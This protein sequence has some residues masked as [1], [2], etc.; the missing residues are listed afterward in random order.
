MTVDI[1]SIAGER[2]PF[3]SPVKIGADL[4]FLSPVALADGVT[5]RPHD[6]GDRTHHE[7]GEPLWIATEGGILAEIGGQ[8]QWVELRRGKVH[9]SKESAR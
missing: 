5:R 8:S 2:M 1:A 6:G 9:L 3:G 4:C 7:K